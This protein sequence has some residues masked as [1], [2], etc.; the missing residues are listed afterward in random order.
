METDRTQAYWKR[1]EG[2]PTRL[3]LFHSFSRV[4]KNYFA[5]E[6]VKVLVSIIHAAS[7]AVLQPKTS[8]PEYQT[9]DLCSCLCFLGIAAVCQGQC[10]Q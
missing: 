6:C 4:T 9:V 10:V 5:H 3:R 2:V 8:S 1:M 7:I